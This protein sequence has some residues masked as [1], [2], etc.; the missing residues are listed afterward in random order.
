MDLDI[1]EVG[2]PS[3]LPLHSVSKAGSRSA[4][5]L[6]C[7]KANGINKVCSFDRHSYINVFFLML[8]CHYQFELGAACGGRAPTAPYSAGCKEKFAHRP[9]PDQLTRPFRQ[10][11]GLYYSNRRPRVTDQLKGAGP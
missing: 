3:T 11:L 1:R 9:V 6:P 10:N 2:A 5:L 8:P 4:L 7:A